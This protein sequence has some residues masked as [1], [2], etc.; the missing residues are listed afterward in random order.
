M[1]HKPGDPVADEL[2]KTVEPHE[3][4]S[5][6]LIAVTR[7]NKHFLDWYLSLIVS[8]FFLGFFQARVRGFQIIYSKW[9]FQAYSISIVI[10]KHGRHVIYKKKTLNFIQPRPKQLS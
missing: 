9:S 2:V 8:I 3:W 4:G 1:L 10:P 5:P 7:F 6:I